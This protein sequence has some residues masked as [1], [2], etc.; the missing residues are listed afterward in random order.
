MALKLLFNLRIDLKHF[1]YEKVVPFSFH[2]PVNY[3]C[4]S[5]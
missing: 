3:C 2:T 1:C 5:K 4:C